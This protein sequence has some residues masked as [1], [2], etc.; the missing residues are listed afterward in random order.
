MT[1]SGTVVI[2]FGVGICVG[3]VIIYAVT[4]QQQQQQQQSAQPY[5]YEIERDDNGRLAGLTYLPQ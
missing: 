4:Q 1:S 3:A 2:A 5:H